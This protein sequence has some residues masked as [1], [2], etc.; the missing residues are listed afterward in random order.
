MGGGQGSLS[1][2]GCR[3]PPASRAPGEYRAASPAAAAAAAVRHARPGPEPRAQPS[4]PRGA[5][6]EP[7]GDLLLGLGALPRPSSVWGRGRAEVLFWCETKIFPNRPG[8]SGWARG[9]PGLTPPWVWGGG[10]RRLPQL[11]AMAPPPARSRTQGRQSA[12]GS[13]EGPGGRGAAPPPPD[14]GPAVTAPLPGGPG[15]GCRH[16]HVCRSARTRSGSFSLIG[17]TRPHLTPA[18]TSPSVPPPRL[19]GSSPSPT[20]PSPVGGAPSVASRSCRDTKSD[21]R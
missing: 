3:L 6:R 15:Q 17:P 8:R 1:S 16:A 20:R 4:Q 11:Y 13:A 2:L 18:C 19:W 21:S 9:A 12:G 7:G 14:P 10:T 5:E